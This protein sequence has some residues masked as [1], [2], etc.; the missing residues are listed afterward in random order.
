LFGVKPA[1]PSIFAGAAVLLALVAFAA[2]M[3][4]GRRASRIEPAS[5]LKNE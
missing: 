2:A 4:P 3:I 5:A 1:D